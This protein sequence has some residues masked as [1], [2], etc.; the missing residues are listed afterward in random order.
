MPEPNETKFRISGD[1]EFSI[2]QS[3]VDAQRAAIEKLDNIKRRGGH[4]HDI[5][6][7]EARLQADDAVSDYR[8]RGHRSR[9]VRHGLGDGSIRMPSEESFQGAME[10]GDLETAHLYNLQRVELGTPEFMKKAPPPEEVIEVLGPKGAE[11]FGVIQR[12]IGVG[13]R[14][15]EVIT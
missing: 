1:P 15:G 13:P 4:I 12:Q 8:N 11:G 9:D 10:A 7:E 14:A 2:T 3:E 5:E 6:P